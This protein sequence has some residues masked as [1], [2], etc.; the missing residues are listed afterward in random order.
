MRNRLDSFFKNKLDS[1]EF[2][3]DEAAWETI[4][5]ELDKKDKDNKRPF[6]FW[7]TSGVVALL[8]ISFSSFYLFDLE[9][10]SVNEISQTQQ[11][12]SEAPAEDAI[13]SVSKE[14]PI[15]SVSTIP[16]EEE[17]VSVPISIHS[18]NSI[19][20]GEREM[21]NI[22]VEFDT[23]NSNFIPVEIVEKEITPATSD[24]KKPYSLTDLETIEQKLFELNSSGT[25]ELPSIS[26]IKRFSNRPINIGLILKGGLSS[27]D[28]GSNIL[29]TG[30]FITKH[31]NQRLSLSSG[32]NYIHLRGEFE[33]IQNTSQKSYGFGST[34]I[35]NELTPNS[36]GVL[37]VPLSFGYSKGRN[38]I[39]LG[40]SAN[41]L[42]GVFGVK[43]VFENNLALSRINTEKGQITNS[44]LPNWNWSFNLCFERN[45]RNI[46]YGLSGKYFKKNYFQKDDGIKKDLKMMEGFIKYRLF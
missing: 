25:S 4:S 45:W 13:Q 28:F 15:N 24:Y 37:E 41:Y 31:I 21:E 27:N 26:P 42:V 30:I 22:I 43:E 1:Q 2:P 38:Q 32:V 5:G 7:W 36:F 23:K 3:F 12:E 10:V 8:A 18:K 6:Y 34:T 29:G 46:S 40:A 33:P 14:V 44:E 16:I 20:I 9:Q 35:I 39:N 11:E 19:A 17:I